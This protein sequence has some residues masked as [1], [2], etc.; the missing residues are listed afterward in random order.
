[1]AGANYYRCDLC[2]AR[3][4]YDA[5]V[6]WE[7]QHN[8]GQIAAL[9]KQCSKAYQVVIRPRDVIVAANER[10]GAMTADD[11]QPLPAP[12]KENSDE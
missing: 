7:H 10:G 6:D 3:T 1:M 2:N 8:L 9:C 12:P 5:D 11:W 4:F